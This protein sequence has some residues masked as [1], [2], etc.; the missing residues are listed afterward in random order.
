VHF[1]PI[2]AFR[3]SGDE[4][5]ASLGHAVDLSAAFL[6]LGNALP[7][8]G[9]ATEAV[10]VL[11]TLSELWRDSP[12]PKFML[13]FALV[14]AGE[15]EKR[16]T[17]RAAS[18]RSPK[19][20]SSTLFVAMA[21]AAVGERERAFEWFAKAVRER[22]EWMIWFAR[23]SARTAARGRTVF[24]NLRR[25]NNPIAARLRRK[26]EKTIAVLPLRLFGAPTAASSEDEFSASGWRT[27]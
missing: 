11:T 17:L 26:T 21:Q 18:L 9:A 10:E 23:T 20:S 27:R 12:V 4:G 25:T 22:D 14:A 3:G 7:H 16:R 8:C 19:N 5:E 6:H 13:C 1:L 2:T 15:T 24:R